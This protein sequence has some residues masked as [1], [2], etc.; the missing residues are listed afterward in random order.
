MYRR[1]HFYCSE[2]RFGDGWI[3][4]ECR[5]KSRGIAGNWLYK[6]SSRHYAYKL[7]GL[8]NKIYSIDYTLL[9]IVRSALS[10]A[11][12]KD[13]EQAFRMCEALVKHFGG[14]KCP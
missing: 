9:N 12:H 2:V 7:A 1:H 5:C 4:Y 13:Y 6:V 8:L 11:F 3:I 14:V 10:P